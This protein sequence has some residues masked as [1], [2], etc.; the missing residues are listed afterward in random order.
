MFTKL[1]QKYKFGILSIFV[2]FSEIETKGLI[3]F[4]FYFS[5]YPEIPEISTKGNVI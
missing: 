4:K 3:N 1:A 2:L 5:S